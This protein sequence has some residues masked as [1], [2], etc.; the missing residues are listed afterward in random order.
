MKKILFILIILVLGLKGFSQQDPQY[1]LYMFNPI[2]VNPGYAG[3]RDV[4]SAVLVH[5][6]QW[7]GL[8]GAPKTQAFSLNMPLNKSKMGV[9]LQIVN[10]KIGAHTAQTLKGTYAYR[11][12]LGRGKLAFGLSGGILNYNFDWN[13]IDYQQQEDII[14]TQAPESFIIPIVDFG[15]YYNTKTFYIGAAIES[16]NEAKYIGRAHV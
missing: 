3:S 1:S 10:D 14:P 6:S 7:I 9:G 11:L 8:D 4:L 2:G 16:I 5:R 12:R 15:M 13:K